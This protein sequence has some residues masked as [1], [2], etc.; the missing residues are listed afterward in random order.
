M[1]HLI[2]E[3]EYTQTNLAISQVSEMTLYRLCNN[4]ERSIEKVFVLVCNAWGYL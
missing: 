2:H 1:Q 4:E 3:E